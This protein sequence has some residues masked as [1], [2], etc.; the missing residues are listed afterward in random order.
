MNAP[1]RMIGWTE[2]NQ[3]L[4]VA[5]FARLKARLS[6]GSELQALADR[7]SARAAMHQPPAIDRLVDAF[8]LSPFERDLVLLAAGVE[9]DFGFAALCAGASD[10]QVPWASFALALT[11][12]DEP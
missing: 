10:L 11:T 8:G 5:E 9:M 3:R 2:A 6:G 1:E 7:D 4:L 12:L